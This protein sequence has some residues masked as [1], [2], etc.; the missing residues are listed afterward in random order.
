MKFENIPEDGFK[1]LIGTRTWIEGWTHVD[2]N[3][4][5]L[6]DPI[7]Q[8][9]K[10]VDVIADAKTIPLPDACADF[11]FSSEGLEHFSHRQYQDVLAEWCRLVKPGGRIRIDV[12]DALLAF[13]QW[14]EWDSLEGDRAMNRFLMGGQDGTNWLWDAHFVCLTPRMLKDD[15]VNMGFLIEHIKRGSDY[16]WL[17]VEARR[18]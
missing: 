9:H 13:T 16:G 12:P 10:P 2:I 17:S 18:P 5:P 8:T 3:P 14:L 4:S 6:W 15:F 7:S 1:V 11:V